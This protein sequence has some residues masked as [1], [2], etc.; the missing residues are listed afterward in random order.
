[1]STDT[2]EVEFL[3]WR[4]NQTDL[5]GDL[6][7]SK[8]LQGMAESLTEGMKISLNWDFTNMIGH[9]VRARI[10]GDDLYVTVGIDAACVRKEM[11]DG[12]LILRPGF[13]MTSGWKDGEE[14]YI[15]D[16]CEKAFVSIVPKP[17]PLPGEQQ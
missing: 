3:M 4:A 5:H 15:I 16:E 7:T 10:E 13:V 1:M 12:K 17:L 9:V 8:A 6:M 11:R 2:Q 14:N